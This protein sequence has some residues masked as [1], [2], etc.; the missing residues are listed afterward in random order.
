MPTISDRN[1]TRGTKAIGGQT[2]AYGGGTLDPSM[3][4]AG[5]MMSTGWDPFDTSEDDSQASKNTIPAAVQG[6]QLV[7]KGDTRPVGQM[8]LGLA[9]G[10]IGPAVQHQRARRRYLHDQNQQ[11]AAQEMLRVQ[12]EKQNQVTAIQDP[13]LRNM[14]LRYQAR[15]GGTLSPQQ[16]AVL[17]QQYR[18][19]QV[20]DQL[21]QEV[22]QYFANP[23]LQASRG[24]Y[25]TGAANDALGGLAED[26]KAA[27]QAAAF[28]AA[29]RG[30]MG[31]STDIERRSRIATGRD[32]AAAKIADAQVRARE[33]FAR[34]DRQDRQSMLDLIYQAAPEEADQLQARISGM[35]DAAAAERERE[36]VQAL[37]DQIR[38][39]YQQG[40]QS[41]LAGGLK[42]V[43]TGVRRASDN[44]G[45][46]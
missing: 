10:G 29:G 34:G 18:T 15:V 11:Q 4:V 21:A 25:L 2:A 30:T 14:L 1:Q 32:T 23:E 26:T 7:G 13:E 44:T 43:A 31:G 3:A 9:T 20:R 41:T 42:T 19:Q 39:D 38:R 28:Q 36:G 45:G 27:T 37:Y 6:V 35:R 24:R 12:A 5:A 46:A 22:N 16:L 40:I 33:A 8:G 17:V